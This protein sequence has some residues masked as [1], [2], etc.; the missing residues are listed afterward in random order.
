[1][2]KFHSFLRSP[3]ALLIAGVVIAGGGIAGAQWRHSGMPDVNLIRWNQPTARPVQNIFPEAPPATTLQAFEAELT[4]IAE[5]AGAAVVTVVAGQ[6]GQGSGFIYRS[7]GWIVTNGHVADGHETVEVVMNDGRR[8]QGKVY[9]ANDPTLDLALIKVD[10]KDLPT[11]RLADSD[12]V[13]TGQF[14]IAIGAPFGYENTVTIGH[15]SGLQRSN[16]I[17]VPGMSMLRS[18]YGMIQTDASINPGNSGGPLIDLAGNVIGVNSY[19]VSP[20]G[21][22]VGAGFAIPAKTVKVF[23]D[24]MIQT[25]RLKR[26]FLGVAPEEL[27]PY[28]LKELN[29]PGG[30]RISEVE[31]DTPAG[32]AGLRKGDIITKINGIVVKTEADVRLAMVAA[33]PGDNV[34]IEYRRGND[35]R[36]ANVKVTSP[37][38]AERATAPSRVTPNRGDIPD[39]LRDFFERYGQERVPNTPSGP[40]RLGARIQALTDE[41]R[42]QYELPADAKGVVIIAIEPGSNAEELG[43]EVGDVLREINGKPVSS[44]DDV[45][46]ALEEARSSG[47][48]SVRADRW[49]DGVRISINGAIAR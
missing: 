31:S 40:V 10:A 20:T 1:M 37:P 19:I 15:V 23:A 38:E 46:A 6:E 21:L 18:Y 34:S 8:L 13:K 32:R 43:L 36:T 45:S 25:G 14:A 2:R 29:L 30:A 35:T 47:K 16:N 27:R 7:D 22:N 3:S 33:D 48:L 41:V 26:A 42:K 28:E 9:S 5:R 11:L 49:K 4:T 39:E 44:L 17:P 12:A 24:E